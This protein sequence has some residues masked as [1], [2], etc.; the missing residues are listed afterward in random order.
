MAQGP[1]PPA[2]LASTKRGAAP[3]YAGLAAPQARARPVEQPALGRQ[4]V[5]PRA[6]RAPAEQPLGAR[7]GDPARVLAL[8]LA[9]LDVFAVV[10]GDQ[11]AQRPSRAVVGR[12]HVDRLV[13]AQRALGGEPQRV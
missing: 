4:V 9:D 8:E 11:L 1:G 12:H 6:C 5:A 7:A 3:P 10:V 13:R 2:E